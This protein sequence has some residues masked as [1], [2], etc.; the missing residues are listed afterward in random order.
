LSRTLSRTTELPRFLYT[1]EEA[2][3]VLGMSLSHFQ[4]HVQPHLR[5]VYSGSLRLYPPRELKRWIERQVDDTGA[6]E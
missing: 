2:A 4:R 1:R 3:R 5:C 6:R